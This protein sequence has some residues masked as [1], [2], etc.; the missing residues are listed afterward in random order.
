MS[1]PLLVPEHA[2]PR[3][4]KQKQQKRRQ[5]RR[6]PRPEGAARRLPTGLLWR[7][8]AQVFTGVLGVLWR[9]FWIRL[10]YRGA[11]ESLRVALEW[12]QLLMRLGGVFIKVGQFT[13][14]RTD[15]LPWEVCQ[16]FAGL[17]DQAHPIPSSQAVAVIEAELQQP[18]GDVFSEFDP[19]PA[20]AAS[21][22]QVHF[23][24]LRESGKSVAIKVQRPGIAEQAAVD[25]ALLVFFARVI[26]GLR[27]SV[28]VRQTPFAREIQTIVTEE[29]SYLNEARAGTEFRGTLRG[30]KHVYAPKVY[31]DYT[32][33]RV[34]VCERI[35]GIPLSHVI[36][37]IEGGNEAAMALYT[38]QFGLDRRKI[39][40]RLYRAILEQQFE[41]E[42][43]HSDPHPGNLIVM[44]DNKICFI[45]F[46]AVSYYGPLFRMKMMR[47]LKAVCG[48]N[49]DDAIE[50]MLDSWEPLPPRN[51]DEFKSRLK[52]LMQRMSN[53]ARSRHGDPNYKSNG[54]LMSDSA[55][56]GQSLGLLAPW[57]LL[58]YNRQMWQLDTTVT[59]LNPEFRYDKAIRGYFKD[60]AKRQLRRTFRSKGGQGMGAAELVELVAELPR[61]L[62]D[63][64]YTV[65]SNLRRSEHMYLHSIGKASYLGKLFFDHLTIGSFMTG[66]A[67]CVAFFMFG[68][69]AVDEWL[70]ENLWPDMPWWAWALGLVYLS[71]VFQRIRVRFGDIEVSRD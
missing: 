32:T 49:L 12:R 20:A 29:L 1:T 45:D 6:R 58:R 37:A 40:K 52:P 8:F 35:H 13:A 38:R 70:R 11:E 43:S 55:R 69:P 67:L 2:W 22:G 23:G 21:F 33:E 47:M 30:R 19:V 4:R 54:R 50:A 71:T 7:R 46:G 5:F 57:E 65:M 44:A 61:D 28:G 68:G 59:T 36:Q 27:L 48:G 42:I 10:R 17:L 66:A 16:L 62:A 51:V 63:I 56:I 26:D 3:P 9:S 39:A 64:R 53:H 31:F 34:L 15:Q 18:L 14:V 60:R 24:R 25:V 41:H